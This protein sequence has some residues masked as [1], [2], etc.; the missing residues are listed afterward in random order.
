M[1]RVLEFLT[2]VAHPYSARD[3]WMGLSTQTEISQLMMQVT[4]EPKPQP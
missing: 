1:M 2:Y 3:A 4:P